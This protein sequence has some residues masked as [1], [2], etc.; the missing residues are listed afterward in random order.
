MKF[1]DFAG[2]DNMKPLIAKKYL[3][4]RQINAVVNFIINDLQGKKLSMQY[5]LKFF[6]KKTRSCDGLN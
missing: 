1:E 2:D 3:N 6:G 4:K 5:C